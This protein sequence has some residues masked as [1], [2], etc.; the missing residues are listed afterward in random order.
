MTTRVER[1]EPRKRRIISAVS[2]AAI[3]PSRSTESTEA[4]TNTDWSNSSLISMPG[5][6]EARAT[7]S[8]FLTSLTTSTVEALPFLITLSRTERR[9]SDRTT[10]CCTS[11]PSDMAEIPDE[12]RGAVGV[13]D[14]N[15]VQVVDGRRY[16]IGAHGVLGVADFRGA[17]G[18]GQ[19]LGVDGVRHIERGQ[20][21]GQQLC[22]VEIDHDLA[23]FAAGRRRKGD[24]VDRRQP[25]P[26][27]VEAVII[28]LLF[29][30]GIGTKTDLQHRDAGGVVLHDERRLNPWRHQQPDV[31]RRRNDL[32]DRKIDT[33]VRLKIDLLDRDAVQSLRL[34]IL[35]PTDGGAHRV[36]AVGGD[37]LLHLG[38]AE[39]GVLP[40][41][42][43]DRDVD[44]RK[45]VRRHRP[46]R[47]DAEKQD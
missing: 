32:C 38:R 15:V 39:T 42:S 19:V 16:C 21:L 36:F 35:D 41:H 29:V 22:R 7:F 40:D 24:A 12:N 47:G 28:E 34:D 1:Q 30:E 27:I 6:A 43:D 26:Q 9:P 13:F 23:I 20:P 8:A 17:G 2:P 18:Q 10:F 5:G 25:L 14:W 37:A 44:L 31:V 4:V 46:E 11:E 33:D 45:N 3:A